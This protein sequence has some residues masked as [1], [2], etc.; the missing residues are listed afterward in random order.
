MIRTSALVFTFLAALAAIGY[1]QSMR[2]YQGMAFKNPRALGGQVNADG[3]VAQ[4]SH[5][6]VV[7]VGTGQ[8]EVTF[9][10]RYFPSGCPIPTI[11]GVNTINSYRLY[12]KLC[13][14]YDVDFVGANGHFV[15]TEF[16]LIAV[17]SE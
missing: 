17:A 13:N 3:T 8:Y 10:E 15:D 12:R 7:H 6:S 14:V 5:F 2:G 11:S 16:N 9:S 1:A 4:G